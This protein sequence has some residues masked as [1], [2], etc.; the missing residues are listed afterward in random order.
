M[1][2]PKSSAMNFAGH[3]GSVG[4]CVGFSVRL[5]NKSCQIEFLYYFTFRAHVSTC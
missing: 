2:D 3:A 1:D 5:H 4:D